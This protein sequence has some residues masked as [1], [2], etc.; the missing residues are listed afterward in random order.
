M[1]RTERNEKVNDLVPGI[2]SKS[3][4]NKRRFSRPHVNFKRL[5]FLQI[6]MVAKLKLVSSA[7]VIVVSSNNAQ[8]N[9]R[10]LLPVMEIYAAK[11]LQSLGGGEDEVV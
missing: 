3:T 8:S 6:F 11:V 7:L 4:T 9:V 10:D 5:I 1:R 2:A